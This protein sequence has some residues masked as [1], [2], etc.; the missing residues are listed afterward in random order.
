MELKL[1][2]GNRRLQPL[3]LVL[4]LFLLTA[5]GVKAPVKPPLPHLPEA[6]GRLTMGQIGSYFLVSWTIP[7]TYEDGTPL[8][9][10]QGFDVYKT[11]YDPAAGCPE[12]NESKEV[13]HHLDLEF[14]RQASR[15]G[16]LVYFRDFDVEPDW[17][18]R[19]K[20]VPFNRTGRE[21]NAAVSQKVFLIPPPAPE[22]LLARTREG[23]IT[24]EWSAVPA[25]KS[26]AGFRGYNIYRRESGSPAPLTPLNEDYWADNTFTDS[27]AEKG[28]SYAYT[29]RSVWRFKDLIVESGD[30][31]PVSA[32]L[33]GSD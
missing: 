33:P 26:Q 8:K 29:L 23:V 20:V 19:Y 1:S 17:G 25:E 11:R 9:D 16:D 6:P 14:L 2:G 28:K 4:L 24:L 31:I 21:G 5:C 13:F 30:S 10:L 32:T 15:Q 3:L 18:Y 27:T 7:K 12:C 22:N